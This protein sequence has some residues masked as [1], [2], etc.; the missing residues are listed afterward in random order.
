MKELLKVD[1]D[2]WLEEVEDIRTNHYPKFGDH[3]PE[4]L[5]TFL[6]SLE[7]DLRAAK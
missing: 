5:A 1:I 6:D 3:L 4:E 2:G 7:A